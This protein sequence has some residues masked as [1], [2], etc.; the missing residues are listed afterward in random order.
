[1]TYISDK[2]AAKIIRK[3][4]KASFP[5]VKFWVTSKNSINVSWIDG[6]TTKAVES[7]ANR[8]KSIRRDH[9][10][11]DILSGGNTYVFVNRLYSEDAL[12]QGLANVRAKN[13]V[14]WA[15]VDFPSVTFKPNYDER[16]YRLVRQ[17][18]HVHLE[19][20]Y[21][22]D[23]E[24]EIIKG[25]K[26]VDFTAQETEPA[27]SVETAENAEATEP[28]EPVKDELADEAAQEILDVRAERYNQRKERR[29]ERYEQLAEKHQTASVETYKHAKEMASVIPFGQ[30]ILVGH[31]SENRDRRYRSRIQNNFGKSFKHK[32]TAEYYEQKAETARHNQSISSDDPEA[33]I[34]VKKEIADLEALQTTMK[35]A[36]KIV[37]D[38][39][40]SKGEK[41]Q[42]LNKKGLDGETLMNPKWHYSEGFQGFELS[43]NNANINRLRKR[44]LQLERDLEQA[45]TLGDTEQGYPEHGLTVIQARSINRLQLKFN[46][47]PNEEIRSILKSN[48]FRWAPSEG[49]WQRQLGNSAYALR[50][51]MDHFQSLAVSASV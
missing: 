42:E 18:E 4:L 36:N 40:L 8:F 39:K 10:T 13:H 22:L 25:L 2:E 7:I 33:I 23:L 17:P 38:K 34:K 6:P 5:G 16:G 20:G 51:V 50:R 27:Q 46:G 29:I 31:Y 14:C 44:L 43:N 9:A 19:D 48:G 28:T 41:I 45:A 26:D 24:D 12:K 3:E 30:P 49:A 11:G 37:R 47:K 21:R 1:M 15:K 35:K 32:E